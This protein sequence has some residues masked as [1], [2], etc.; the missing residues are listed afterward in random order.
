MFAL[1]TSWSVFELQRFVARIAIDPTPKTNKRKE[2]E[3]RLEEN[4]VWKHNLW[5]WF[6]CSGDADV[7]GLGE[8]S[9]KEYIALSA[10][11]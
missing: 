8:G 7:C 2:R 1:T 6:V 5:L 3:K 9:T 4:D 10:C 11:M